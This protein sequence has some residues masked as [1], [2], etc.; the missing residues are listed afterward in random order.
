[1]TVIMQV[2]VYIYYITTL[3]HY[4]VLSHLR[5]PSAMMDTVG[6]YAAN[7]VRYSIISIAQITETIKPVF[8][9]PKVLIM[10]LCLLQDDSINCHCP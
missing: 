9:R 10:L 8:N 7:K 5:P 4:Y 2:F 1:M 3:L 6:R